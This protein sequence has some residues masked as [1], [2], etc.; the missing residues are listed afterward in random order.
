[1]R[2]TILSYKNSLIMAVITLLTACT[3]AIWDGHNT[4]HPQTELITDVYSIEFANDKTRLEAWQQTALMQQL[5]SYTQIE[6]IF[7]IACQQDE[8]LQLQRIEQINKQLNLMGYPAKVISDHKQQID[9]TQLNCVQIAITYLAAISPDCPNTTHINSNY[10]TISSNFGC[11]TGRYLAVML[12]DP[13]DLTTP[14]RID[15]INAERAVLAIQD[16]YAGETNDLA[17]DEAFITEDDD[18]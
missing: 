6:D 4:F 12:D 11:A 7:V 16:Y 9:N 2:Q 17:D 5:N 14:R 8:H 15:S 3:P 18:D 10:Q 13:N 1:M